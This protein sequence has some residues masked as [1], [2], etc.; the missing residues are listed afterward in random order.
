[1]IRYH[2]KI[3][4]PFKAIIML[5]IISKKSNL[6]RQKINFIAQ[7]HPQIIAN[8]PLSIY[9]VNFIETYDK[10]IAILKL[11]H[12][13]GCFTQTTDCYANIKRFQ[14]LANQALSNILLTRAC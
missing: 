7:F 9:L 4:I 11:L 8:T 2:L 6:N 12:L 3:K 14:R 10:L 5:L 13:L 1:M